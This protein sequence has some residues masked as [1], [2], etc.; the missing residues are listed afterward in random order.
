[1]TALIDLAL[2]THQTARFDIT[3]HLTRNYSSPLVSYIRVIAHMYEINIQ[4]HSISL[5]FKSN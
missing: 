3:S 4:Y 2:L 5:N 1:M